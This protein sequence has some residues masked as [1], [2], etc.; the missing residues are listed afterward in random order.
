MTVKSI[1]FGA[2]F[3]WLASSFNALSKDSGTTLGA[4]A[5]LMVIVL[6]PSVIQQVLLKVMQPMSLGA[7]VT[8][9]ATFMALGTCVFPPLIGGYFRF[10]HAREQ[11]QPVRATAVFALFQDQAAALRMI[12]TALLFMAIYVF[13]L[14]AVNFATGG[15]VVE[16]IKVALT[17]PPGQPP[18]F[19]S[20]PSGF[21]LWV[22]AIVFLGITLMTAY[23]LAITQTALSTRTPVEAIGDGF[24]VTLRNLAVFAVFYLSM[25]F[26]GFVL[27]L[28][29]G[30]VIG[31]VVMLFALISPILVWV[32]GIPIYLVLT[33]LLYV[34]MFGFNYYAWR[35][36]LGDDAA[37]VEQQIAA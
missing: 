22:V 4:T 20:M 6:V 14:I 1:S 32:I 33:L 35:G 29:L 31:L 15:Y 30:L 16:L 3:S 9:Q 25:G 8:M 18:V 19:P 23:A 24:A 34:V 7:V 36:T 21:L 5:L 17:T 2:P 28:V 12:A 11:G 26:A 10:L 13:A 27:A 37:P